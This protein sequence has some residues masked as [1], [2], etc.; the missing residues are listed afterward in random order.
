MPDI[1]S[2]ET[3]LT[4]LAK[5]VPPGED[6]WFRGHASNTWDLLSGV[7][8]SASR[9]ANE[10]VLLKRFIQEAKRHIADV[11]GTDWDWL[12]LAQHHQLPTRLLDWSENPL[13]GLFFAADD[14]FAVRDNPES[15]IDGKLWILKPLLLNE[16]GGHRFSA[17]RDLPLFGID[18]ELNEY[19]PFSGTAERKAPIAGLAARNFA[20]IT[21]QWGTFTICN[22]PDSLDTLPGRAGFIDE[23]TVPVAA[24]PRIKQQLMTLGLEDR[25]IYPDLFRLGKRV[26]E[27]YG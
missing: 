25:T 7:F 2:V 6:R 11:P 12:F 17:P 20:R 19:N 27:V 5:K 26:A 14:H 16:A 18:K 21:A 23:L 10:L 9:Q 22:F 13:V 24:K 1:D 15:A 4:Y 3:L 8:R